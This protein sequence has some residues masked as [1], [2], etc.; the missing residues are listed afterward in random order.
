MKKKEKITNSTFK[1]ITATGKDYFIWDTQLPGFGVR[2]SPK[3]KVSFVYQCRVGKKQYRHRIGDFGPICAAEARRAALKVASKTANGERPSSAASDRTYMTI[4]ELCKEY[5]ESGCG[6]KKQSTISTDEGRIKRHIVPLLGNTPVKDLDRID[7]EKFIADIAN[8]K[9]AVNR[10]GRQK[11]ART[12]VKGGKGTAA[13]TVGL[14]GGIMTFA[15]KLGVVDRNP[16]HGVTKPKDNRRERY[17]SH[18]ELERLGTAINCTPG[19]S[20]AVRNALTIAM[21]TG[22]RIGEVTSLKWSYIDFERNW[23]AF[24]DSKTGAKIIQLGDT[25]ARLLR[26]LSSQRIS[27]YVFP[28]PR[29]GHIRRP[30]KAW[31]KICEHAGLEDFRIHDLRHTFA[32]F[33]ITSIKRGRG[34]AL[35]V[36]Q[37]LLGHKDHASTLRYVHLVDDSIQLAASNVSEDIY[38]T[39]NSD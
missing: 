25:P 9:T 11:Y 5:L 37:K 35:L 18:T 2:V 4:K 7:V 33:A 13:R 29:G 24:P 10:K 34:D 16:V 1:K 8:G 27:D 19:I 31:I 3:G 38:A 39:I 30:G 14:L 6:H 15:I 26:E 23:I 36:V 21:L 22:C 17:L 12:I 32:S 28:S 20:P